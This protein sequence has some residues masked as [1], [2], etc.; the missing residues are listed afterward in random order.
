MA[1][2]DSD[3]EHDAPHGGHEDHGGDSTAAVTDDVRLPG[4]ARVAQIAGGVGVVGVL[5]TIGLG[6]SA[7][8]DLRSFSFAY[9]TAY[10]YGLSI[11]LGALVW[12]TLQHLFAARWSVVVR[13]VG[14]LFAASTPVMALLALP[15]LVPVLMGNHQLYEWV[16]HAAVEKDHILHH[17]HAYLNETF[18]AVRL[19]VYFVFWAWLGRYWL[20]KSVEQDRTK[21]KGLHAKLYGVSAPSMIALALTLSFAAIDLIMSLDA[22]WFSTIFGVYYFSGAVVAWHSL[23]ALVLFWL[24]GQ[25]KL[26]KSVSVHH[27]HDI[28]KMMFA[29]TVFWAYIAFSQYM[30]IWYA[31]VPEETVWYQERTNGPWQNVAWFLVVG[32]FVVPF[33]FLLSRHVKRN[34][35]GL[36]LGAVW[37]LFVHWVDMFWLVKPSLGRHGELHGL[38]IGVMDVTAVVGVLGMLLAAAA[39]NARDKNLIPLEDERLAKSLAFTNS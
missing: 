31:N 28:G 14:E 9:L 34:R 16:D 11:A 22:R 15:I 17:K 39:W 6:V 30:L 2:K 1:K 8:D 26:V 10:V 21:A 35:A 33:L 7:G 18:F 37:L 36:K 4:A 13:R 24:Q 38:P 20:T 5:A 25:G 19:V 27:F 29:F 32:H 23:F 3:S 12:V